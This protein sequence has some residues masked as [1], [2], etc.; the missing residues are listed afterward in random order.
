M[1]FKQIEE[2]ARG[3]KTC[4][5]RVV[6]SS[7]QAWVQSTGRAAPVCDTDGGG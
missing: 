5:Q 3:L 6:K 4:T 1:Y 7:E 2:I